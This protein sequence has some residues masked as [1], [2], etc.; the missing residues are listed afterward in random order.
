MTAWSNQK[1]L[2]KTYRDVNFPNE[3]SGLPTSCSKWLV[4]WTQSCYHFYC[5]VCHLAKGSF[6]Y[7]LMDHLNCVTHSRLTILFSTIESSVLSKTTKCIVMETA[8]STLI[9]IYENTWKM[10][11][12]T[13]KKSGSI[14]H[15]TAIQMSNIDV[16]Q[17]LVDKKQFL[18]PYLKVYGPCPVKKGVSYQCS[19]GRFRVIEFFRMFG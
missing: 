3:H 10:K 9:H 5:W 17:S 13:E 15:R 12:W 6:A 11:F 16:C 7:L 2:I 8:R 1:V 19:I 18:Y 4:K 14:W